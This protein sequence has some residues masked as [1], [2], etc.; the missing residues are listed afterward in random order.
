MS[1][2]SGGRPG[3]ECSKTGSV[4]VTATWAFDQGRDQVFGLGRVGGHLLQRRPAAALGTLV[5]LLV[6]IELRV[7]EEAVLQIVDAERRSLR[8]RY[9]AKMA[10]DL[11][12]ALVRLFDRR[13]KLVARDVHVGLEG[14]DTLVG[15]VVHQLARVFGAGELVHLHEQVGLRALQIRTG[16]IDVRSGHQA[17]VDHLLQVQVGVGLDASRWCAWW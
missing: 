6:G 16:D 4:E 3:T 9:R 10:G 2:R 7:H 1:G 12:A 15:P 14:S 8:I 11:E 13:L 5:G 17:G